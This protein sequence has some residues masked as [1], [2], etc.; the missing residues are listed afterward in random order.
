MKR[1]AV[2]IRVPDNRICLT[3]VK[4]FGNPIISTT[5]T[6]A[7]GEAMTDPTDMTERFG[8]R[9]DLVID[10][11]IMGPE[12]SS[13]VSLVDDTPEVLREGKGD[14]SAFQ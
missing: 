1:K 13:V 8:N 10:G 12:L 9:V 4:E 3:L 11:G 14:V 6:S 2:G 7:P 5:V